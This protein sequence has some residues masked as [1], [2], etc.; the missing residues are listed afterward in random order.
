MTR[1]SLVSPVIRLSL[2]VL[3]LLLITQHSKA[4]SVTFNDTSENPTMTTSGSRIITTQSQLPGFSFSQLQF[5]GTCGLS[6]LVPPLPPFEECSVI[7]SQPA[8]TNPITSDATVTIGEPG[9]QL[10]S[11]AILRNSCP[12]LTLSL[13]GGL[14]TCTPG[15]IGVTFISDPNVSSV[16]GIPVTCAALNPSV[17]G[18]CDFS[19]TGGPQ[20]FS[21]TYSD[22]T[23]DVINFTS[24]VDV[25]E[26]STF[27][28]FGSGFAALAGLMC[29]KIAQ[30]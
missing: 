21:I 8:N 24:D 20:V 2:A 26:P 6:S 4:D 30:T 16:N 28:L 11:D 19:E 3:T 13:G 1:P 9:S 14:A 10:F 7:I 27:V 18:Q 23:A 17:S 12:A 25:P 29:R 15:L 5:L 22:G